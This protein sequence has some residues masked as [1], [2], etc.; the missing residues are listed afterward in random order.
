RQLDVSVDGQCAPVAR[1]H[2]LLQLVLIGIRIEGQKKDCD[3]DQRHKKGDDE[4]DQ[5]P[6]QPDFHARLK[7]GESP[8]AHARKPPA[9]LPDA[10]RYSIRGITEI[11]EWQHTATVSHGF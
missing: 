2:D 4:T 9:I 10:E 7:T 6:L 1:V 11:R 3:P 5:Y 8:D